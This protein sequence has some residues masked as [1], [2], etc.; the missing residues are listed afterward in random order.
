MVEKKTKLILETR[1][2]AYVDAIMAAND[3]GKVHQMAIVASAF[4]P[5]ESG[6]DL[7]HKYNEKCDSCGWNVCYRCKD[8]H[9]PILCLLCRHFPCNPACNL[10]GVGHNFHAW[11]GKCM[12]CDAKDPMY[13]PCKVPDGVIERI[14]EVSGIA[15]F[16]LKLPTAPVKITTPETPIIIEDDEPK[17]S[18]KEVVDGAEIVKRVTPPPGAELNPKDKAITALDAASAYYVEVVKKIYES[19]EDSVREEITRRFSGYGSNTEEIVKPAHFRIT[20][21]FLVF[22]TE[23]WFLYC[24]F[25]S[26][27]D[28]RNAK[29]NKWRPVHDRVQECERLLFHGTNEH[30]LASIVEN[31]LD[32]G[33]NLGSAHGKRGNYFSE[34]WN[35]AWFHA[36]HSAKRMASKPVVLVCK[37][38][39]GKTGK[40]N[41]SSLRPPEGCD[42]G[43]DGTSW[44]YVV[45]EKHHVYV[46]YAV[47]AETATEEEH[48]S[49]KAG[50]FDRIA[51][52]HKSDALN[53]ALKPNEVGGSSDGKAEVKL[54][55]K[56]PT[57]SS[58]SSLGYS[59]TSPRYSPT[60]PPFSP[61]TPT[62]TPP[63]SPTG[64]TNKRVPPP[65]L[66]LGSPRN[67]AAAVVPRSPT[68]PT[69]LRISKA[70]V[71]PY[72]LSSM[73]PPRAP[74][75]HQLVT[76]IK[77]SR[78]P[79]SPSRSRSP[80]PSYT[81]SRLSRPAARSPAPDP[82][83]AKN[84]PK[85]KLAKS[86][87]TSSRSSSPESLHEYDPDWRKDK[88]PKK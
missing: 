14:S 25:K 55:V 53:L 41:E 75:R 57:S 50:F 22:H 82:N 64:Q 30:S 62:Y 37:V 10:K 48:A 36:V 67:S 18:V 54:P 16:M 9:T 15:L 87:K 68:S 49:A 3:S 63:G 13:S 72:S 60:S 79:V 84:N 24:C 11:A 58:S 51:G 56:R 35:L 61:K 31:G 4:P 80:S 47:K 40:T 26:Q 73:S 69:S 5:E 86:R 6:C 23:Y 66:M 33:F 59:P 81:T 45:W 85:K 77:Q 52:H 65:P 74:V 71:M 42:S 44:K 20:G 8:P 2:D 32:P 1:M 21:V 70:A 83:D 38:L 7:I 34:Q 39:L 43:G 17:D 78:A 88:R 19:A 76:S 29:L 46:L 28:N 12:V 27:M